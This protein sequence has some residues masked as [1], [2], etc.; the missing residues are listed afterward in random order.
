MSFVRTLKLAGLQV[1]LIVMVGLGGKEYRDHHR[2]AS[3]DLLLG[4]PLDDGDL[5]YLSP[6]VEHPEGRYH[7]RR[8]EERLTAMGEDEVEE[9]LAGLAGEL[10]ESGLRVGRY[11]I[12]EFVY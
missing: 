3:R 5:I 9:E 10:R 7:T 1:S 8:H 11:D 12:R 4:L 2:R 6:F